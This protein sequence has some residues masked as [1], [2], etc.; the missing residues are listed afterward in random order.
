MQAVYA[1]WRAYVL[2]SRRRTVLIADDDDRLRTVRMR[3]FKLRGWD[4]VAVSDKDEAIRQAEESSLDFVAVDL[5]MPGE[6][7]LSPARELRVLD[8]PT[9]IHD[10]H[11]I[12]QHRH[13]DGCGQARYRSL[14]QQTGGRGSDSR[15]LRAGWLRP[16]M[17][18]R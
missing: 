12:W 9:F 3:A 15:C 4:A 7:G 8:S 17:G 14:H 6:N 11:G 1:P 16:A 13:G 2:R 18:G 5:R 10:S